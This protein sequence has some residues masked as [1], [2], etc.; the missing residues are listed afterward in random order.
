MPGGSTPQSQTQQSNTSQN[1]NTTSTSAPNPFIQPFLQQGVS[2]LSNYYNANPTAPG[3]YPGSTIAAPSQ[4]TQIAGGNLMQRG[5][6]GSPLQATG[7][8]FAAS[9]LD[10]NYLNVG[11][12]PNFQASLAAGFAPQNEQFAN[13][14]VPGLRSQFEGSGR[15][16]GGADMGTTTTALKNLNQTQSNASAQAV[17]DAYKARM[18]N[19]F[20]VLNNYIPA[21]QN[22]DYQN[23]AAQLQAGG[24]TDQANQ[25]S[26]N[27]D[28][29]RYNYGTTA[30]PNYI[31]DFLSRIGAGYPGGQTTGQG[32]SSGNSFS[33]GTG[34]PA[35]N[36]T[37]S[38][39][40]AG[41]GL[42]G[43]G[44]QAAQ[45]PGIGAALGALPFLSDA[46]A[47]EDIKP[48]GKLHDG[49]NVYSYR[50]KGQPGT[51]IGLLA[52]EVEQVHP[53]AVSTHGSGYK[54]VDYAKATTPVGGLF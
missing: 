4:Q 51:Q 11:N 9:V 20:S 27:A 24:M 25:N 45:I 29:A 30:Q 43:L 23:I 35:S 39:I 28:V 1:Q 34:T 40:G 5:Q 2:D 13:V 49:Q 37:S 33:Q 26:I 16:L 36:G 50:Y 53:E 6:T 32:S 31:S 41:F 14:T 22:M 7:N 21:S 38:A 8:S 15:N 18:A 44:L 47:K 42:A 19:Q 10:P 52:Q 17:E 3:Y 46:R 54:M 12:D 48:V